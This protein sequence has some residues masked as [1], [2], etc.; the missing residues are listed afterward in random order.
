[1]LSRTE[2]GRTYVT[3]ASGDA[4]VFYNPAG[5]LAVKAIH[6]GK[7]TIQLNDGT[8]KNVVINQVPAPMNLGNWKLTV[9]DWQPGNSATTTTKNK[10]TVDLGYL[11]PWRSIPELQHVS[12]IGTYTTSFELPKGWKEGVGAYVDLGIVNFSYRL[13]IN[14]KA[15]KTSQINT[16]ID[17]GPFI[18]SG[19]NTI[20]VEVATTLNN[21]LKKLYNVTQRTEDYYGLIGSGGTSAS[22]GMGGAVTLTPYVVRPIDE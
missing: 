14:G 4:R 13:I 16:C 1:M 20:E 12:G 8:L 11:R 2:T 3:M 22:D 9:E 19:V 15:I 17:I 6:N 7:Y 18:K 5:K 10:L 21:R